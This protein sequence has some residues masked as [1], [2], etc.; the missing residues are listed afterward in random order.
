M[1]VVNLPPHAVTLRSD[2]GDVVFPPSGEVARVVTRPGGDAV[3]VP[4]LGPVLPSEV[5]E[6]VSGLPDPEAGKVFL[7]SGFV[8]ANV[9][10]RADVVAPATGPKHGVVRD[11]KGRIQAVTKF[12]AAPM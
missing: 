9:R 2:A 4:G 10:G 6:G 3:T 7:V 11:D 5:T 8:L 1:N 12:L